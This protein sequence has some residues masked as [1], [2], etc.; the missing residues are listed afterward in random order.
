MAWKKVAF[1]DSGLPTP[2]NT[3]ELRA[4]G[5]QTAINFFTVDL[6]NLG[7]SV[8]PS[9]YSDFYHV[10][11][12]VIP[13]GQLGED[14]YF[15][16]HVDLK[17][18]SNNVHHLRFYL[19]NIRNSTAINVQT[20][21]YL[22]WASRNFTG[23]TVWA[24]D[25]GDGVLC[26]SDAGQTLFWWP[27]FSEWCGDWNPQDSGNDLTYCDKI[28][29]WFDGYAATYVKG[30]PQGS[31]D[32]IFAHAPY[33]RTRRSSSA[34]SIDSADQKTYLYEGCYLTPNRYEHIARLG[35]GQ[36]VADFPTA[37]TSPSLQLC[38]F[39]TSSTPSSSRI[40]SKYL[41]NGNYYIAPISTYWLDMGTTEPDLGINANGI[42]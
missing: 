3:T 41:Y 24:D 25:Q 14:V 33:R 38:N 36:Y 5:E 11:A 7:W 26:L 10:E 32:N 40:F 2:S 6:V 34:T 19:N 4:M 35:P 23:Y 13:H 30:N 1:Y 21:D 42:E 18:V 12:P 31:K 8:V 22:P 16:W 15:N 20:M 28:T 9:G 29:P 17:D 27:S 39:S 37:S